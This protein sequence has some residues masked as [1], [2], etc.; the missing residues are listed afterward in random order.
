MNESQSI[1]EA[2][3]QPLFMCPVCLRKLQ[4]VIGFDVLQRYEALHAFFTTVCR[5]LPTLDQWQGADSDF[6]HMV[7]GF[8]SSLIW[9][10]SVLAFIRNES[11]VNRTPEFL[12]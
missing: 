5:D 6:P 9:L 7:T 8:K 3:S 1:Q 10:Q 12:K 4:K 11:K 2:E